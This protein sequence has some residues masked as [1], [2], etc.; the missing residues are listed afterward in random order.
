M[1]QAPQ[2]SKVSL[3]A[4]WFWFRSAAAVQDAWVALARAPALGPRRASLSGA[5]GCMPG[6]LLCGL[7]LAS[8][9][10]GSAFGK[11]LASAS[12][13]ITS[14]VWYVDVG[15]DGNVDNDVPL[16]SRFL[17]QSGSRNTT[18]RGA[19]EYVLFDGDLNG[20]SLLGFGDRGVDSPPTGGLPAMHVDPS[21]PVCA[22]AG[23]PGP[24][25]FNALTAPTSAADVI[26]EFVSGYSEVSG[27]YAAIPGLP[28]GVTAGLRNDVSLT[29][30]GTDGSL[31]AEWSSVSTVRANGDFST[32]FRVEF[33]AQALAWS[34]TAGDTASAS[35]DLSVT[36]TGGGI[37]KTWPIIQA[38]TTAGNLTPGGVLYSFDSSAAGGNF[39]L[40]SG[41][42]YTLT[43]EAATSVAAATAAAPA[44]GVMLLMGI[45]F[46]PL[47]ASRGHLLSR[48]QTFA[49]LA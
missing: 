16:T 21:G 7:L 31:P 1:T 47:L 38:A 14:F 33:A 39:D 34:E 4:G 49:G 15:D 22:G 23:C 26:S 20:T 13:N 25:D 48:R 30:P 3:P 29:E 9:L 46:L 12:L 24:A 8:A 35:V 11:A 27:Y 36:F 42:D 41:T 28:T 6:L 10:P 45:G 19:S 40:V 18:L 5:Q 32:Y 43:V 17:L 44:P 37:D 2:K